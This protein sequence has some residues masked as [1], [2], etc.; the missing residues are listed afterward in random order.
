MDINLELVKRII[1]SDELC[2]K[3][4]SAQYKDDYKKQIENYILLLCN[5]FD[6]IN[7]NIEYINRYLR[8]FVINNGSK[9]DVFFNN[10]LLKLY[11]Y[12]IR[13]AEYINILNDIGINEI[14]ESLIEKFNQVIVGNSFVNIEYLKRML[15][16]YC[17]ACPNYIMPIDY[18]NYFTYYLV[19]KSVVLDYDLISYFYKMFSLSF[20][21]SK[22]LDVLFS[23]DEQIINNDPY[24]DNRKRKIILYKHS[25]G[26][27]V[28][29]NV[30]GDIFYQIKYLYLL[31]NINDPKNNSYSFE[32]LRFV[33]EVCLITILGEDYFEEKYGDI[34]FS[35]DLKKQSKSTVRD[36][37]KHLGLS[38]D[39]F[40]DSFVSISSSISDDCDKP[41]NIDVLFDLVLKNENPNLLKSII[42]NYP[43][44][45]CEYKNDK[46]KSLL[47]LLLDIYKNKK[48]L[49]N[50]NKDLEWHN[51]KLGGDEDDLLL[52]K[53]D[54]LKNKICVCTS[55]INIMSLSI[56]CGD[57][58]SD[59]II[60]SISDL[61]T[62]DTTDLSIQNDICSILCSIIPKKISRLC[63]ER[64]NVY[65]ESFKKKV[66]KCYLDSMGLVR[67][68][69]DSVYFMKVYSSL[70]LCI[71][72]FDI[73]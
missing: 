65:K 30:L 38:I 20:S 18:I 26:S 6:N 43:I 72:A 51:R 50:F 61:I 70:E 69:F 8:K 1:S 52:P 46:R 37:Y 31:K 3:V 25:I 5:S 9:E 45:G 53:I 22:G 10:V 34:S 64:N 57:M 58:I 12:S 66:I 67:N 49:S 36:F 17:Y 42:R 71:K 28:D 47:T 23:I 21:I 40:S 29:Y 35:S 59:D 55:Y 24:Y 41:I 19:S 27:K 68:N 44:L 11:P 48:L 63:S 2:D 7:S 13:N 56:S 73:D 16:F 32:Q 60:R 14:K 4:N 62:Y 39:N 15:M 54:R 33:K